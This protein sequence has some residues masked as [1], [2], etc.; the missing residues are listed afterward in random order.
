MRVDV[1]GALGSERIADIRDRG[2]GRRFSSAT[3]A[4]GIDGGEA[5]SWRS[6]IGPRRG[7][8][9]V[10]AVVVGAGGVAAAAGVARRHGA[11]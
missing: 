8:R 1:G 4:D 3:A 11:V 9:R 2:S 5:V 7:R 6:R 10:G